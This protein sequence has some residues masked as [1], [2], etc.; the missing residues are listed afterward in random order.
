ME[1]K[2]SNN[3]ESMHS[4]FRRLYVTACVSDDD[5]AIDIFYRN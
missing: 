4:T 1:A 3:L 2:E 5:V